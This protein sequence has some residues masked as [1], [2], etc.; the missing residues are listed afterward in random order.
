MSVYL[1]EDSMSN[2]SGRVPR[3]GEDTGGGGMRER[4]K[5]EFGKITT[6]NC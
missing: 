1:L 4:G 5:L 2:F 3:F 6:M